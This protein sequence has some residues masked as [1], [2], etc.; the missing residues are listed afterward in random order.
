MVAVLDSV[1]AEDEFVIFEQIVSV[2]IYIDL[3][4]A[5]ERVNGKFIMVGEC[6]NVVTEFLQ[7]LIYLF[8]PIVAFVHYTLYLGVG[9]EIGS[10]PA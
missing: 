4:T 3:E 10:F 6:H 9:M 5:V 2:F 8:R 7:L 1:A